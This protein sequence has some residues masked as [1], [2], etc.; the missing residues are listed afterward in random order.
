[1]F[2]ST[3]TERRTQPDENGERFLEPHNTWPVYSNTL[4][5]TGFET[6]VPFYSKLETDNP[7][8]IE[9]VKSRNFILSPTARRE[10]EEKYPSPARRMIAT[11]RAQKALEQRM[12]AATSLY[13][14]QGFTFIAPRPD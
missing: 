11:R 10:L 3:G 14:E 13:M 1:M 9:M 8:T 4:M 7:E 2:D 6:I 12:A 5:Q